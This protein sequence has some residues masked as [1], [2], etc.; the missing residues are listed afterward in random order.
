MCGSEGVTE[1]V[2]LNIQQE[3]SIVGPS[4]GDG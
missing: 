3:G 4:A 2:T 1:G